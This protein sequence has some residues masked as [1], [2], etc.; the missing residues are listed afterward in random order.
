MEKFLAIQLSIIHAKTG[1]FNEKERRKDMLIN[2]FYQELQN[3][4]TLW[5]GFV[6]DIK[7]LS[8]ADK[9]LSTIYK[10]L[11]LKKRK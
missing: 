6:G 2:N 1:F 3:L 11:N 10:K 9:V 5:V 4:I 7:K 8:A